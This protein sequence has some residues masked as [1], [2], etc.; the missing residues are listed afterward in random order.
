MMYLY[1]L[2]RTDS[3]S[4][5]EYDSAIVAAPTEQDARLMNPDGE[6]VYWVDGEWKRKDRDGTYRWYTSSW[7]NPNEIGRAHV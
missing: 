4:Y 5:D 2:E 3:W 6:G 1:K 7:C